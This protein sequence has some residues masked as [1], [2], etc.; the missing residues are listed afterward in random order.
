MQEL[1]PYSNALDAP[2][3][4][5]SSGVTHPSAVVAICIR[6]PHPPHICLWW[7]LFWGKNYSHT[8]MTKISIAEQKYIFCRKS[9][10]LIPF[11]DK[12]DSH[13]PSA[14]EIS[15]FSRNVAIGHK[16]PRLAWIVVGSKLKWCIRSFALRVY[17][18]HK[19][20]KTDPAEFPHR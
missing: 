8:K 11:S 10:R 16:N 4:T 14:P 13:K 18:N 20:V 15:Q 19:R 9:R 12:N 3:S 17:T 7:V 6:Y 2:S 5:G 1:I